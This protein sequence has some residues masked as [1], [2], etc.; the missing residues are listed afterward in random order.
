MLPKLNLTQYY[1]KHNDPKNKD[2]RNQDL[3]NIVS[4][5][6]TSALKMRT[7]PVDQELMTDNIKKILNKYLPTSFFTKGLDRVIHNDADR[8]QKLS[9]I[10]SDI[11]HMIQSMQL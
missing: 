11:V 6:I 5:A 1:P 2:T 3:N 10:N 9:S 4:T 8:A 7:Q